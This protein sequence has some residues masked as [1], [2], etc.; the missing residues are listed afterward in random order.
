MRWSEL[1]TPGCYLLTR[2][3]DLLRVTEETLRQRSEQP[4]LRGSTR[5]ARLSDDPHEVLPILRDI[6]GVSG[7]F[8][9]F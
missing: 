8:V 9:N 1:N 3:G 7:Y 4:G 2:V 6:A 5:L